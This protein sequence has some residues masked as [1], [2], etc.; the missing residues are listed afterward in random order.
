MQGAAVVA[1]MFAEGGAIDLNDPAVIQMYYRYLF[2][3]QRDKPELTEAIGNRDYA[4]TRKEYRLIENRGVQVIVPYGAIA[5]KYAKIRLDL[6]EHGLG[7][8]QMRELISYTVTWTVPKDRLSSFAEAVPLPRR[9]SFKDTDRESGYYL[10]NSQCEQWY[11]S[12]MG[13]QIRNDG[14]NWFFQ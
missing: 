10:L 3:D 2:K 5:E 4:E 12:S 14:D 1:Q 9:N 7:R 6:L 8:A 13:L 11:K